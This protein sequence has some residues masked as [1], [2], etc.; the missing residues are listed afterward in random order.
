[1]K[2]IKMDE[3]RLERILGGPIKI[4]A[5]PETVGSKNIVLVYGLF[6]PGEGLVPHIHPSSEEIYHVVRGKGTVYVGR[7]KKVRP[8]DAGM[9]LYI[10][11]GEI[12][13]VRNTG[14]KTLEVAFCLSPGTEEAEEVS[15]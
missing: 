7:E 1:M 3:A 12:H 11:P 5:T 2:V 10:P 9:T 6:G 15:A 13:F 4:L 8:I 14:E